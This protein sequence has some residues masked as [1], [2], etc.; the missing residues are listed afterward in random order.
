M[1]NEL[2]PVVETAKLIRVL[3]PSRE[4]KKGEYAV[5]LCEHNGNEYTILFCSETFPLKI[6]NK[7]IG[8]IIRVDS[9][10]GRGLKAVNFKYQDFDL[11][12][13][14]IEDTAIEVHKLIV[15][16]DN[17]ENRAVQRH[18]ELVERINDLLLTVEQLKA[19]FICLE[20]Y[21]N[22]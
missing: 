3:I 2:Y 9:T 13:E 22:D 20:T 16:L 5:G 15:K 12:K 17:S 1:T 8:K 18:D 14:N 6:L 4:G 7:I 19:A 11:I 10:N 21:Q